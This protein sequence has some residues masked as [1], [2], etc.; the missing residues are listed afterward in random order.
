MTKRNRFS[1]LEKDILDTLRQYPDC[2][3]DEMAA[4]CQ[5]DR[6]SALIAVK[7]LEL[8]EQVVKVRVGRARM[9]NRYEVRV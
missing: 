6:S 7:R 3:Y 2:S 4:R 9:P 5:C 8:K 1:S